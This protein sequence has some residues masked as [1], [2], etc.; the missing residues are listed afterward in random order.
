[1]TSCS[2]SASKRSRLQGVVHCDKIAQ[3]V[4]GGVLGYMCMACCGEVVEYEVGAAT[5]AV[6]G[7]WEAEDHNVIG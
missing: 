3:W 4:D 7:G 5:K 2:R 1:M 6:G